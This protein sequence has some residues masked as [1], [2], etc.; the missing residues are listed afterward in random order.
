MVVVPTFRPGGAKMRRILPILALPLLLACGDDDGTGV[1]A[2][3][4]RGSYAAI[5]TF[6]VT[7]VPATDLSFQFACPGSLTITSQSGSSFSGSFTIQ[8]TPDCD[9]VSGTVSGTIRTDGGVNV[10]IDVPG[11]SGDDFENL[12]LGCTFVSGDSQFNGTLSGNQLTVSASLTMDCSD[13]LVGVFRIQI[14]VS[15]TGTRS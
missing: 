4:A 6:T 9:A 1:T 15:I 14:T 11:E 5:F 3:D 10:T 2:P 13:P 7:A 8:S 12:F